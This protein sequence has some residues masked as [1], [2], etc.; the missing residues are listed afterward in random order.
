MRDTHGGDRHAAAARLGLDPDALLDLSTNTFSA[1]ADL[2]GSILAAEPY[3]Y[4]EYPDPQVTAL[5]A[6]VAAHEGVDPAQVLPGNGA[7]ELIW[8]T[9][10]ALRPPRVL[11]LGPMFSEYARAC[12]ALGIAYTVLTP[13][14]PD[15]S[16]TPADLRAITGFFGPGGG[17]GQGMAIVCL[18]NNPAGLCYPDMPAVLAAL[19]GC[20]VLVDLSY[21]EFLYG[22]ATYAQ[23][24][25][26][27]LV[28]CSPTPESVLGLHSLTKFFCCPGLR[29]GYLLAGPGVIARVRGHQ[30]PWMVSAFAERAGVRLL[31]AVD[32][33]RARLPALRAWRERMLTLLTATRAFSPGLM[34]AG[35]SFV[36]ARLRQGLDAAHA[37][38]TLA[39]NGVLVR[40][41]D[42]IP[43]MPPG[44]VR[45]QVRPPEEIGPLLRG[46]AEM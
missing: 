21:R 43:G 37:R 26:T 20:T 19:A 35:P 10:A 14:T 38:D 8:L 5:R 34:L 22:E 32:A 42:T 15:F 6:A 11:M 31:A 27:R 7:A 4:T 12:D 25:F 2:T 29:L 17:H 40:A 3:P 44:F 18:P 30:P 24:A 33:Y 28:A 41:C 9:L 13:S 45:M 16:P 39:A 36:T 46:L 23:T 1:T